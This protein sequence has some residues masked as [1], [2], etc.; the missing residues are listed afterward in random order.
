MSTSDRGFFA[1]LSFDLRVR[2]R[3]LSA[4]VVSP[5]DI[6]QYLAG[7][8]DHEGNCES[9]GIPQPALAAPQPPA[10]PPAPVRVAPAAPAAHMSSQAR[11]LADDDDDEDED[12]DDDDDDLVVAKPEEAAAAPVQGIAVGEPT[13]GELKDPEAVLE[14]TIKADAAPAEEAPKAEE[15]GAEASPQTNPQTN[16]EQAG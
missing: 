10:P 15:G 5:T 1:P 8:Q 16:E 11:D 4:G 9:L 14:G 13:P 12:E 3:M 2:E 6:Q 7:L